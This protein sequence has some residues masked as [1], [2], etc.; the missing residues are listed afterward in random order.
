MQGLQQR[1]KRKLRPFNLQSQALPG[2]GP[3][4][5]KV[6]RDLRPKKLWSQRRGRGL[7]P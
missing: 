2:S 7:I 5:L 6:L 3:A 1:S 4:L